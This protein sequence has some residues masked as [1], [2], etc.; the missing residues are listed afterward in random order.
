VAMCCRR[1]KTAI[2]PTLKTHRRASG[3]PRISS[4]LLATLALPAALFG[5]LRR[6]LFDTV[7]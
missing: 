2:Y 6:A 3:F 4:V 7:T 5:L 1:V